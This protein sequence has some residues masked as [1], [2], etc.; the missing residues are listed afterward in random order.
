MRN[1]NQNTLVILSAFRSELNEIENAK[2]NI[3]LKE[4]LNDLSNIKYKEVVGCWEGAF[5]TSI[6]VELN[7]NHRINTMHKIANSFDQDAILILDHA[8]NATLLN[9]DGSKLSIG[10][11]TGVSKEEA[12]SNIGYTFCSELNQYYICK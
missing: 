1:R 11:L 2:R 3:Q 4:L 7:D 6:V 8:R 10:K 12:E 5:E 9:N